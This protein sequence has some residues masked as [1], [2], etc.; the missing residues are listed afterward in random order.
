MASLKSYSIIIVP[1]DHSGTRQYRLSRTMLMLLITLVVIFF[2]TFAVFAATYTTILMDA[3]RA[4]T[5][6]EENLALREQVAR[7]EDLSRELEAMSGLRAQVLRLLGRDIDDEM[8]IGAPITV[9]EFET[10][11]L[12]DEDRLEQVFADAA[13][14]PFAPRAWPTGG[15]VRREFFLAASDQPAHPG[16]SIDPGPNGSVRAAGRGQVVATDY[17]DETGH[18]LVID[19]GYGFRTRYEN[20]ARILV[21]TGRMVERGQ[22]VAELDPETAGTGIAQRA[23]RIMPGT[24]Y[25]ELLVDG[26]PVDPRGYLDP[27]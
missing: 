5:L 10:R 3:R 27:R 9:T 12:E 8:A 25:F 26:T 23:S 22:V 4:E 14:Q 19:H 15:E 1:S 2:A 18:S 11:V 21:P 20:L 6:E 17:S 16:L 13:R 7:V 24:L